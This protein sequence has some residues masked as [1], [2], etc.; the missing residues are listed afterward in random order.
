MADSV[1]QDDDQALLRGKARE[2]KIHQLPVLGRSGDVLDGGFHTFEFR[3][4]D[5]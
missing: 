4:Q 5:A 2:P 3:N 1:R